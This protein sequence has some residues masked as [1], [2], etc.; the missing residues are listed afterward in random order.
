MFHI[1]SLPTLS[2]LF[3][4]STNTQ[5]NHPLFPGVV[6]TELRGHLTIAR[7]GC[8]GDFHLLSTTRQHH[9]II[10]KII[11]SIVIIFI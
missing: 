9:F 5:L 7:A 11:Q 2:L 6:F 10:L 3:V 1:I 8:V 4:P